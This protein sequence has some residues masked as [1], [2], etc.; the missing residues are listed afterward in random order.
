MFRL[1][2]AFLPPPRQIPTGAHE[3]YHCFKVR[4]GCTK[5]IAAYQTPSCVLLNS[6]WNCSSYIVTEQH[7]K[8]KSLEMTSSITLCLSIHFLLECVCQSSENALKFTKKRLRLGLRPR[9]RWGSSQ[10]SPR[11]PSC[12]PGLCPG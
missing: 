12:H 4:V 9:P 11:P 7:D 3:C 2:R 1:R 8:L 5:H 10:R 6:S